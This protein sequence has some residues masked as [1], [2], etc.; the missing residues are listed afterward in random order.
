V[1]FEGHNLSALL[2]QQQQKDR[3]AFDEFHADGLSNENK[4][5]YM[6]HET[7]K[8]KNFYI[9]R[10]FLILTKQFIW[11]KKNSSNWR[12]GPDRSGIDAGTEKDLW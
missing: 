11:S 6:M 8:G 2:W 5:D 10:L 12:F 3:R 9:W 1:T 7:R 4:D